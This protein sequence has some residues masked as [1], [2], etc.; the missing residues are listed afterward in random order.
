MSL[1]IL[2]M[3]F[4]LTNTLKLSS[5]LSKV[6]GLGFSISCGLI[7]YLDQ[8]FNSL[9]DAIIPCPSCPWIDAALISALSISIYMML[10][11]LWNISFFNGLHNKNLFPANL[12]IFDHLAFELSK[13]LLKT[14]IT[15]G[16]LYHLAFG[17]LSLSLYSYCCIYPLAVPKL[18]SKSL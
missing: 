18:S 5:F 4:F 6:S 17:L 10:Q 15:Y 3:L 7:T 2:K 12:V 9:E 8:L 11:I 13:L 14:E 1:P 16:C